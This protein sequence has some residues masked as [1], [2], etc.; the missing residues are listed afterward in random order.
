MPRSY[1]K[2][3]NEF[4]ILGGN[5]SGVGAAIYL[6]KKLP[7]ASIRIYEPKIFNKPCGGAISIEWYEYLN[8]EFN[9]Y[10][11]E[12]Y[13]ANILRTGLWSGRYVEADCPF[14]LTTRYALQEKLIQKA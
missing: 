4:A 10:L 14:V 8:K 6:R 1:N 5:I 11:T 13:Q 12:A 3:S 7:E 2:L 9:L